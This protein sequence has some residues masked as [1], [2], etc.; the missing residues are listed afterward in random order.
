MHTPH[1]A[2]RDTTPLARR[3]RAPPLHGR[4]RRVQIPAPTA[5]MQRK[6]PVQLAIT[7]ATRSRT[8]GWLAD[9]ARRMFDRG[10]G[11]Q[12]ELEI[13]LWRKT[14]EV[15]QAAL[16]FDLPQLRVIA[17]VLRGVRMAPTVGSLRADRAFDDH[18]GAA[19][20]DPGVDAGA[21]SDRLRALGPAADHALR[22]GMSRWAEAGS[23]PT[24]AGFTAAGFVVAG[25]R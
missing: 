11:H 21:L 4:A 19:A 12:A 7:P 10:H 22:E 18:P 9:R 16:G 3:G 17:V 8:A 13:A 24:D 25:R 23:V 2:G 5:I 15:E 6:F 14:L 20:L 1:D